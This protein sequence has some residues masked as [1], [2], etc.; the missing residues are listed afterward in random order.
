M[1][2]FVRY[3]GIILPKLGVVNDLLKIFRDSQ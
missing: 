3:L 2:G 1:G